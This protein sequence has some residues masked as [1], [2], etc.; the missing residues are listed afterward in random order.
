MHPRNRHPSFCAHTAVCPQQHPGLISPRGCL[1]ASHFSLLSLI[2]NCTHRFLF[3]DEWYP[4]STQKSP[5]TLVSLIV[6]ARL[7]FPP[8]LLSSRHLPWPH[9]SQRTLPAIV[10]WDKGPLSP[11]SVSAHYLECAPHPRAWWHF[12]SSHAQ[13]CKPWSRY[14]G[15]FIKATK[16]R[17]DSNL[18]NIRMGK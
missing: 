16:E 13:R 1:P 11:L 15:L 8:T 2:L 6:K 18:P 7:S 5:G 12:Y 10:T 17:K 9:T 3:L 14:K 4:S